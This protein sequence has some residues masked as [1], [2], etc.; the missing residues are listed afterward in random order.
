MDGVGGGSTDTSWTK[1][2]G[3][4]R[5]QF[6]P[7]RDD[8]PA[9]APRAPSPKPAPR[10]RESVTWD[11][12]REIQIDIER[13]KDRRPSRPP[14]AKD[15]WTE[16]SKDLVAREAIEQMGYE[17]EDSPMFFYVME[18]LQYVSLQTP[19]FSRGSHTDLMT[20]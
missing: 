5:T 11:R 17:Y 1:Y 9:P 14:P 19:P 2:S 15:M 6:I 12:E 3:V 18:Y 8:A 20:G 7:E 16:I 10:P 4:R 13:N